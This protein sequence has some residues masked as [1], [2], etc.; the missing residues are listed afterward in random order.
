MI[1]SSPV[2]QRSVIDIKATVEVHGSI[3]PDFFTTHALTGCDTVPT[4]FGTGKGMVLEVLK[5]GTHSLSHLRCTNAQL[6]DLVTQ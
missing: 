1:M 4:Y 2:H 3:I 6:A 5:T